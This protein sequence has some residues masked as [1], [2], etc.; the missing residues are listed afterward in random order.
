MT[1]HYCTVPHNPPFSYGD[2]LRA[3]VATLLDRDDVP[4]FNKDNPT[5]EVAVSRLREWSERD[6]LVPYISALDGSEALSSVLDHMRQMNPN[7]PYLLF[8]STAGGVNHVVV[9]RGGAVVHNPSTGA[10]L[11]GPAAEGVWQILVMVRL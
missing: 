7:V 2:C 6:G 5:P 9:C 3:C 10:D 11:V 1:L 8:G 4:H